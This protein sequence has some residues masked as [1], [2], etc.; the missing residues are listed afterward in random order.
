MECGTVICYN[1]RMNTEPQTFL[2]GGAVRDRLLGLPVQDRDWVVVGATPE[3]MRARGFRQVGADFPVFL[4]PE[5]QE[6]HALA[7]TER[8]TGRGHGGFLTQTDGVTLEQD[9]LRRDLTINA[10][11]MTACGTLIDPHGGRADLAAGVLRHVSD[12]FAEDPLRVLRVARFAARLGF[13]VAPQTMAL[14]RQLS[15]DGRLDELTAERVWSET[16]RALMEPRPDR[17]IEVLRECG[18]LARVMP[19]V[20]AL[21]G[22]PQRADHHPEVCTGAHVLLCLAVAARQQQPLAVRFAVLTHDLGKGITPLDEL[23]SHRGHEERGIELVERFCERL[24]VPRA[25]RELALVVCEH[26]LR[27][28]RCAEMRPGTVLS[29]LESLRAFRSPEFFGQAL[30]ACEA[31]ARGRLGLEDRDYPQVERL[32]HAA[33]VARQ[34]TAAS[35]MADGF[36][37]VAIAEQLR[38]RRAHALSYWRRA[39]Q[40][41]SPE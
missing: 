6:E 21:F 36:E 9:L 12:A 33:D 18:A 17:Y 20:D 32:L 13:S 30:A 37:G 2:V 19:E 3:L 15:A 7:R 11:A 4:H 28:H 38:G 35:V 23:P 1:T 8:Q 34:V 29:L 5:T 14:M 27:V 24:R 41:V 31:D 26:H 22:V 39:G 40:A 25:V 16:E 10:M